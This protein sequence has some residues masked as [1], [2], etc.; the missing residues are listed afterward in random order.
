MAGVDTEF[1]GLARP[2]PGAA[3]GYLPQEPS[4][5]QYETVQQVIDQ[6]VQSSRD[7]LD[8]YNEMS[9]KLADPDLS[10]SQMQ[11]T[12]DSIEK[13]TNQIEAGNLWE[14]DRVVE[15]AMDSLRVPP[16]DAIIK[17]LSG[18]E[19]RRTALCQLL[20]GNNDMLLLD[21]PTNHLDTVRTMKGNSRGC[22]DSICRTLDPSDFSMFARLLACPFSG[23]H[24]VVGT[25]S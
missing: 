15:R 7:I 10:D 5:D 21:E 23:I 13:I 3:I 22:D 1:D 6:A 24:C 25:I 9:M 16:G 18:G 14:L 2:L 12:M 19:K 11:E 20:L 17:N 4:L 8:K